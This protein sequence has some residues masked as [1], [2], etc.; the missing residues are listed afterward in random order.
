MFRIKLAWIARR[1]REAVSGEACGCLKCE[2]QLSSSAKAVDPIPQQ[3]RW[4]REAA[5]YWIPRFR[6]V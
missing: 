1:D 2:S 6:G 5:A 3:L 4:N